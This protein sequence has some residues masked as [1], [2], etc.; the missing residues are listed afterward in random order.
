MILF[1]IGEVGE[2]DEDESNDKDDYEQGDYV[3]LKCHHMMAAYRKGNSNNQ[4]LL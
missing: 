1:E 4:Q 2:D 3:C